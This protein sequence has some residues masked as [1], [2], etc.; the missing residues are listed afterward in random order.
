MKNTKIMLSLACFFFFSC[1]SFVELS[2]LNKEFIKQ[3]EK[4]L[5]GWDKHLL[6]LRTK[7]FDTLNIRLNSVDSMYLIEAYNINGLLYYGFI[8]FDE[9]SYFHF[10][11]KINDAHKDEIEISNRKLDKT[12]QFII[13]KLKENEIDSIEEKSKNSYLMSPSS[14]Y[15]TIIQNRPKK[16]IKFLNL[17]EFYIPEYYDEFEEKI[18][19]ELFGW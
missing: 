1:G 17:N 11:R 3:K 5:S 12:D 10:N 14:L 7:V 9:D 8:Y 15:I 13:A 2:E 18:Q 19:K 16:K 6:S 4:P